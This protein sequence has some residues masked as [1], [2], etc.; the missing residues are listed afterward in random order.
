MATSITSLALDIAAKESVSA[1]RVALAPI[2]KFAKSFADAEG[3]VGD[4]VKVPV[5]ARGTAAEF[6]A[7]TND[8]TTATSAGVGGKTIELTSHPW[9]SQR[10]L[11][12]DDMET[13]AGKDWVAQTTKN[14]VEAVAKYVTEKTLV[15]A[16]KATGVTTLTISGATALAKIKGIR[17][18]TIAAGLNPA[19]CTLLL[20][21]DLYTDLLA[22]L[23]FNT[24]GGQDALVNGAVEKLFGFG[25]IAELQ[26]E[27]AYTNGSSK[28]VTL[29][30]MVVGPGAI[31]VATRLPIVQN[32][33]LFEVS[34]M[35]APE[36]GGFSVRIRSTGAQSNDAKYLG[37]EVCFGT[38]ALKPA[39]IL[40]AATTAS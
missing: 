39:E 25:Y 13:N 38:A 7:G 12:D 22:E 40:V 35:V 3:E 19:E 17:K 8:Y 18:S 24:L 10:L 15:N 1:A 11:P 14:C 34:D 27:I 4:A 6:A 9:Q 37:A 28:K 33:N 16:M 2:A 26:S 20:P 5:F 21:S 32:E 30:A 23:P 36:I 29:D 31:G